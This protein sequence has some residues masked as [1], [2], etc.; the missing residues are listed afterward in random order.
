MTLCER[1]WGAEVTWQQ[2]PISAQQKPPWTLQHMWKRARSTAQ[3]AFGQELA[4]KHCCCWGQPGQLPNPPLPSPGAAP[5]HCCFFQA[6]FRKGEGLLQEPLAPFAP[7]WL[8]C[9]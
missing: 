5:T 1:A 9:S 4:K 7:L 2:Q 8:L 6:P 3:P